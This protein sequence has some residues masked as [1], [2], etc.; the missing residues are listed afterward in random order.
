MAQK[1]TQLM[2]TDYPDR[3]T[4]TWIDEDR[5]DEVVGQCEYLRA[6]PARE[7]ADTMLEALRHAQK[8]MPHPDQMI[9]AAIAKATPEAPHGE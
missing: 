9:D 1:H 7:A 5:G 4:I 2:M 3:R 8:N 6:T